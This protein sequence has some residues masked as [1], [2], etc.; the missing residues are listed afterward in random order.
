[1]RSGLLASA[2]ALTLSA[3][4]SP[5]F[6]QA[7]PAPVDPAGPAVA[8]D[9]EA[10]ADTGD[11]APPKK[12]ATPSAASSDVPPEP[13]R[14]V[15]RLPPPGEPRAD[16]QEPR[17][18]L[19]LVRPLSRERHIEIGPDVGIWSRPAEGDSI[20]YEPALAYGVHLRVPLASFLAITGY[21]SQASHSVTIP[22]GSLGLDFE[23][24]Q[25]PLQVTHL[26]SRLEPT[27]EPIPNLRLWL[28][29]GIAWGHIRAEEPDSDGEMAY[30]DRSGVY[31]EYSGSLGATWDVIPSWLA[32][33]LSG[34]AGV[35]TA[36]T[37]D[38]FDD[39]QVI[40]KD[41]TTTTMG[42]MPELAGSYSALLG[43]GIVL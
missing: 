21:F 14:D 23:I 42:A 27:L 29:L 11:E 30:A 6:A 12:K 7:A 10:E 19:K 5:A 2:L 4:A 13:D 16:E 33:S 28:G 39:H 24:E 1:M 37:G 43:L 26:G 32:V 35:L 15:R 34:S 3:G 31:L 8:T 25:E 20:E 9:D 22:R 36:Q 18:Y 41:G 40:Q 38:L 17:P